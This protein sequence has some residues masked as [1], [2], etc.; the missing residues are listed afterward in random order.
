M[1][2]PLDPVREFL[3]RRGCA[4]HVVER[5][6]EGL[7]AAWALTADEVAAGYRLG[8]D[9]YRNDVDA[10]Q[11][12][13]EA[14]EHA[15]PDA[16]VAFRAAVELLDERIRV[17]LSPPRECLWGDAAARANAW[18]PER[19]WW[20]FRWPLELGASEQEAASEGA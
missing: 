10:R 14:L 3:L 11:L 5:G 9:D 7:I 2:E 8:L 12:I 1:N 15:D 4:T 6:L 18:T 20:Y 19:N 17:W 13:D 16:R